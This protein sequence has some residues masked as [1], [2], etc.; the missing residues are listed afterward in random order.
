MSLGRWEN[1]AAY[2]EYRKL[3]R[4]IQ[5]K[6]TDPPDFWKSEIMKQKGDIEHFKRRGRNPD[7]AVNPTY[8][9]T[10]PWAFL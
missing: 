5:R 9:F 10:L 8:L 6:F 7:F 2:Y 4:L 3:P 1:K